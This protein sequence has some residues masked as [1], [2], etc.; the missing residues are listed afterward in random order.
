M[1]HESRWLVLIGVL[2]LGWL[3][4]ELGPV[5]TP[6][7]LSA[8]LAYLGD[9]L[10]DRLQQLRLPRGAAVSAVFALF[11]LVGMALLLFIVPALQQQLVT[12][13]AA[14]PDAIEWFRAELIPRLI[15]SGVIDAS[16]LDSAALRQAMSGHFQQISGTL[17]GVFQQLSASG[18]VVI[19]LLINVALVPVLTFYLMRDWDLL[20]ASV[21]ELLPR[22]YEPTAVRLAVEC[23]EV[24]AGFLRGQVLVMVSLA[25]VYCLGLWM[26]GLDLALSVGLLAGM[27]SF[28]PYLGLPVGMLAASVAALAQFH[29]L[30]PLIPVAVVFG[31]GQILEGYVFIPWLVGSRIGIHPAGLIFAVMAGG[32]LFGFFGILLAV[33]VAAVLAVI[34]RHSEGLYRASALYR[35]GPRETGTTGLT[36][37]PGPP[38]GESETAQ[39]DI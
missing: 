19:G 8:F 31:V 4:H 17:L 35:H 15:E 16:M 5:L 20:V 21:R 3:L 34:L 6:F 22:R 25:V 29:D 27:V 13:I 38:A 7:L 30:S 37:P 14:V 11:L 1:W 24:L 18:Q 2:A 9:P 36:P 26:T 10:V 32:Q 33:P 39:G 28:V 23:D 12:L